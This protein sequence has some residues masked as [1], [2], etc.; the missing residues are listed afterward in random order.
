MNANTVVI[1]VFTGTGNTLAVADAMAEEFRRA[2]KT[3]AVVPMDSPL[4]EAGFGGADAIGLAVPVSFI[5]NFPTARRF[6]DSLPPGNGREAFF[7]ATMGSTG[8]G[9]DVRVGRALREKG[10]VP[11]GSRFIRMCANYGG[12][13]PDADAFRT[14]LANARKEAEDFARRLIA[15]GT[16]WKSGWSN[17]AAAFHDWL[18]RTGLPFKFFR[19]VF[20]F[21]VDREKCTGC[22]VCERQCPER[23]IALTDGRAAIGANCQSCQRCIAYCPVAAIAVPKK[24][25]VRRHQAVPPETMT[26]F[27]TSTHN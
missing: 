18:G 4:T 6:I 1:A 9:M 5:T 2:G 25:N 19:F 13:I 7:L 12:R 16:V 11:V 14:I 22:G 21:A 3:A 20:P 27:L 8:L 23:A 10:Y 24:K 26:E 15:G 17:P